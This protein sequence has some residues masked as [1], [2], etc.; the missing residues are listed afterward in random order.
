MYLFEND[1]ENAEDICGTS[2]HGRFPYDE[3]GRIVLEVILIQLGVPFCQ[4]RLRAAYVVN[5]CTK[6]RNEQ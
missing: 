2:M 3:K 1:Y 4:H 5:T 6:C